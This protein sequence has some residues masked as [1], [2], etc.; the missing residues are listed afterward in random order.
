MAPSIP[1]GSGSASLKLCAITKIGFSLNLVRKIFRHRPIVFAV[2][3]M[4]AGR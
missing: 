4:S 1:Y 3:G 2:S